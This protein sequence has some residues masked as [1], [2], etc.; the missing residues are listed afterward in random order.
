MIA[1]LTTKKYIDPPS[2][3][4]LS[5]MAAF[6]L[7]AVYYLVGRSGGLIPLIAVFAVSLFVYPA[8]GL[9]LGRLNFNLWSWA[10]GPTHIKGDHF[11]GFCCFATCIWPMVVPPSVL[12]GVVYGLIRKVSE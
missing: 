4:V 8:I 5:F 12:C 11:F 9:V 2:L 7:T 10:M 3:T 6:A 1:N